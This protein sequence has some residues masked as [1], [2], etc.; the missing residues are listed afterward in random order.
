MK[1]Y[2]SSEYGLYSMDLDCLILNPAFINRGSKNNI[3][4]RQMLTSGKRTTKGQRKAD[5]STIL[6]FV[7]A[8]VA[9]FTVALFI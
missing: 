5:E 9:V 1:E 8:A 3:G 6:K 4:K 2:K 7:A